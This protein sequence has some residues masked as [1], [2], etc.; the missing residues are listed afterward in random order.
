[1]IRKLVRFL[2]ILLPC[3]W[4]GACAQETITWSSEANAVNLTSTGALMDGGFRFELGVFNGSFVP[5]PGNTAEWAAHWSAAKRSAYDPSTKRFSS[6][7]VV[8]DNTAPFTVGKPAYVWGFR[9]S[10]AGGEWI[11]FRS[12]SWT[13]P[14]SG[15]FPPSFHEWYAKDA[16]AVLGAI[17]SSGIPCL[18]QSAAVT[19][20]PPAT[21]WEQWR[22]ERLA[23]ESSNG[24]GDDPD[25]DG[26]PN[27]LEFVFDTP[28]D[29]AGPPTATPVALVDG[30]LQITIPRRPDHSATLVVEVSDDLEHWHSGAGETTVVSDGPAALVVADLTPLD[31]GHPRRF[32]R[33]KAGLP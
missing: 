17:H 30:H 27:L 6:S 4:D 20:A 10:P 25:H 3:A 2:C 12:A 13:W 14:D 23:G 11:L 26:T 9:T 29:S 24:P 15:Q 33:L 1:M 19:D 18:M 28:P 32:M 16:T 22:S 21:S 7:V 31:S 5:G 8:S